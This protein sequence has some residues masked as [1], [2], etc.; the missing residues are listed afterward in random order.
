MRVKNLKVLDNHG[1][2]GSAN[3]LLTITGIALALMYLFSK[4]SNFLKFV[5]H[6]VY[7]FYTVGVGCIVSSLLLLLGISSTAVLCFFFFAVIVSLLWEKSNDPESSTVADI[8]LDPLLEFLL[9]G[10]F[11]YYL[12]SGSLRFD[13]LDIQG[14]FIFTGFCILYGRFALA[15][16][17]ATPSSLSRMGVAVLLPFLF[18]TVLHFLSNIAQTLYLLLTNDATR[19]ELPHVENAADMT[20]AVFFAVFLGISMYM[21]QNSVP[22]KTDS[23]QVQQIIQ[24]FLVVILAGVLIGFVFNLIMNTA[25]GMTVA[26]GFVSGFLVLLLGT[27]MEWN[28][29]LELFLL[30][31]VIPLCFYDSMSSYTI[32]TP[33]LFFF[34]FLVAKILTAE[35]NQEKVILAVVSFVLSLYRY[36][37]AGNMLP[38]F[39]LAVFVLSKAIP[40]G[41]ESL[42]DS[43]GS[44]FFI[45]FASLAFGSSSKFLREH[46]SVSA[47]LGVSAAAV[48]FF[49]RANIS[50]RFKMTD[51]FYAQYKGCEIG[52]FAL[53][54]KE[55]TS[56]DT[57]RTFEDEFFDVKVKIPF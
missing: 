14:M 53:S 50:D 5:E 30:L 38:F 35:S 57:T 33:T 25:P 55:T 1:K 29:G 52:S 37:K 54:K 2:L 56:D 4:D 20:Q 28:P 9:S 16:I 19:N 42:K 48:S 6:N 34:A 31:F 26:P 8:P 45:T 40:S 46:W 7:V 23:S 44:I 24:Q 27:N 39:L 43:F 51:T 21:F 17:R 11:F 32:N 41:E 12:Y 22:E 49:L 10:L 13:H 36:K 15:L 47:F 3:V 18:F